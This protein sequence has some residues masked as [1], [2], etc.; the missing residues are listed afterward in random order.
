MLK[1]R[2]IKDSV[3]LIRLEIKE[4]IEEQVLFNLNVINN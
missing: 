2:V 4:V 1:R 3:T